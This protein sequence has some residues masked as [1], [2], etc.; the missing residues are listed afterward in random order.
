MDYCFVTAHDF[1]AGVGYFAEGGTEACG[2]HGEVEEVAFACADTFGDGGEGFFHLGFVAVSLHV[3]EAFDLL[4]AHLG[5]VDFEDVDGIFV[6]EAI[7]VDAHDGLASGVDAGLG[8]GRGFLDAELGKTGLDG[9]GHAAELLDFLYMCPCAAGNLVGEGLNIVGAGPGVDLLGHHRLFLDVDLGVAGDAGREI[10]GEGDSLVEGVGVEALGV[11]Q[12]CAHGLD[13]GAAYVVEGVLLGERP[14][15]CLRVGAQGERFGVLGVELLHNLGPKH[16]RG[17]HLGH[18]HE[19]VH[20]DSPEERQAGSERVDI[21]ACVHA[22]AEIF[23]AVGQGV[24]QLD[25]ACCA[26]FL[27][28]VAGDGYRVELGHVLRGV[29]EDVGDDSHREFRRVDVGVAHHEFLEDVVL[30]GTGHFFEARALFEAGVDIE[31]EHGEHGAVHGHGY[32]H[33]VQGDAVEEH[34]HVFERAD[35]HAC[36]AHV[37]YHTGVVG[38]VA[39]VCGKVEGHGEA[40]LAGSEVAAVERV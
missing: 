40:F 15:R 1:F 4:L 23:Q 38:V 26:G 28:V 27:H 2:L 8:A 18:F 24:C 29:L 25:V 13:A 9:L 34:F 16:T 21:H 22:G 19:E 6:V 35:R 12:G 33:L 11:A 7:F 14:A 17:A 32:R 5:I 37:A 31:G 10:G 36:L 3:V 30:D 20:A 39:A